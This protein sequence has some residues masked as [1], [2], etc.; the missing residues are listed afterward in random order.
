MYSTIYEQTS[1]FLKPGYLN[2]GP[3][4]RLSIV[5]SE[6]VKNVPKCALPNH[7]PCQFQIIRSHKQSGGSKLCS[8]LMAVIAVK[9]SFS[10]KAG[11]QT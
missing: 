3:R 6:S 2:N 11:I 7:E 9:G 4:P 1:T 5:A 8:F 10:F